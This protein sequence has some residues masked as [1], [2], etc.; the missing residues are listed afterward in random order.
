[1]KARRVQE[2][3]RARTPRASEV[4][5]PKRYR[6]PGAPFAPRPGLYHLTTGL[7]VI[8]N[9][10]GQFVKVKPGGRLFTADPLP[11]VLGHPPMIRKIGGIAGYADKKHIRGRL[12]G[13]RQGWPRDKKVRVMAREP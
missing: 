4:P 3:D 8:I 10:F 5:A 9:K 11:A 2:I 7:G 13:D 12:P 1:M 6:V